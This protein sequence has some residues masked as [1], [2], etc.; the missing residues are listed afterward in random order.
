MAED[1]WLQDVLCEDVDA[2]R[3]EEGDGGLRRAELRIEGDERHGQKHGAQATHIRDEVE[4]EGEHTKG[5]PEPLP[6]RSVRDRDRRGL[7]VMVDP[8]LEG[9]RGVVRAC[10]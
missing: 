3:D 9:V 6:P 2:K 7:S 4:K 10:T 8:Y 1:L 5:E